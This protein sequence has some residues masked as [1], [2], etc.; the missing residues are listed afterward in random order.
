MCNAKGLRRDQPAERLEERHAAGRVAPALGLRNWQILDRALISTHQRARLDPTTTVEL[1]IASANQLRVIHRRIQRQMVRA[2]GEPTAERVIA[3]HHEA[4]RLILTLALDEAAQSEHGESRR[5][6]P[7]ADSRR[8]SRAQI[9]PRR[10]FATNRHRSHPRLKKCAANRVRVH[11]R[12][13]PQP[14]EWIE[15]RKIVVVDAALI[16][17]VSAYPQL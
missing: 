6:A 3:R 2:A 15:E 13:T 16:P 8:G 4:T 11:A 14:L 5:A 1:Q 17:P 7:V 10:A 9:D 12:S